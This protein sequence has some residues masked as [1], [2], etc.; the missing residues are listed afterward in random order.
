MSSEMQH[1]ATD[2]TACTV[3]VQF[4]TTLMT[5]V[6]FSDGRNMHSLPGCNNFVFNRPQHRVGGIAIYARKGPT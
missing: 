5:K 1:Q 3:H 2:G 6:W 4:P